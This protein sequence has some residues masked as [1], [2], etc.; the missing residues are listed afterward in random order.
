MKKKH[1]LAL[2]TKED[3]IQQNSLLTPLPAPSRCLAT[4]I[5]SREQ[6]RSLP[7]GMTNHTIPCLPCKSPKMGVVH[8]IADPGR[9]GRSKSLRAVEERST[10]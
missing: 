6:T 1:P 7:C 8:D 9:W 4:G 10:N 2:V 3:T 5:T